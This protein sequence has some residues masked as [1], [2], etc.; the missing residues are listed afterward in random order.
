MA[1]NSSALDDLVDRWHEGDG[2]GMELREYLG[3]SWD[4]YCRWV[5]GR[6]GGVQ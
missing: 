6:S 5:E 4:E 3:M 2:L 1:A